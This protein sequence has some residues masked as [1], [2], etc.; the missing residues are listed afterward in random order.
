MRITPELRRNP[1]YFRRWYYC[2]NPTCDTRVI[3]DNTFKVKRK[4]RPWAGS[5]RPRI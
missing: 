2:T 3:V 1:F 4:P 5:W